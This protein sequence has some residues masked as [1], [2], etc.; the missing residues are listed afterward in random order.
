MSLVAFFSFALLG[1]VSESFAARIQH[2]V[3]R[4]ADFTDI[5]TYAW[6][7]DVMRDRAL[8]PLEYERLTDAVDAELAS[9]GIQR[10]EE[11]ADVWLSVEATNDRGLRVNT[12]GYGFGFGY[13]PRFAGFGP[14]AT[15]VVSVEETEI[16]IDLW[17]AETA[18]PLWRGTIQTTRSDRPE[19]NARR[20][21][22]GVRKVFRRF[23]VEGT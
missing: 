9:R 23:P 3:D 18:D 10:V 15:S 11:G 1:T 19:R 8:S 12:A 4:G 7:P 14:F 2:D 13:G 21:S 5:E 16:A 22:R 17:E 20:L 6:H